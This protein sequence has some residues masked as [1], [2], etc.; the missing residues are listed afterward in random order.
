MASAVDKRLIGEGLLC[1]GNSLFYLLT[2][3]FY[4]LLWSCMVDVGNKYNLNL[5]R[6]WKRDQ[7]R[8]LREFAKENVLFQTRLSGAS[9]MTQGSQALGGKITPLV[10]ANLIKKVGR[11]S[12]GN[13]VW[14]LD[15]GTVD[16]KTL[17]SYLDE[18]S[19]E[20]K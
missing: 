7:L 12:E 13:F 11:D 1:T 4:S 19:L 18:F 10:R 2:R 8:L 9:G 5:L 15:E 16:R 14:T 20:E 3:N 17:I 6:G